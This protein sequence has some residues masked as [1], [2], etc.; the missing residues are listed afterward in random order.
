MNNFGIWNLKNWNLQKFGIWILCIGIFASSCNEKVSNK[1]IFRYNQVD[2]VESMDPAF[3]KNKNV[4]WHT[5]QLYNRLIE[6]GNDKIAMPSLAKRWTI[7]PDRKTYTFILRDDVYFHDNE[8]FPNSKGRKLIAQDV[9]FSFARIIDKKTASPGSWIFN[10]KVDTLKPFIALNDTTFQLSLLRPFN[11]MMGILSM[12]YCNI[13]PHEA[14]EKWGAD[15]RSHPCGT[16]AFMM[17]QWD[18]GSCITFIKNEHYWEKDSN[19]K[20]LPY[21]DGIKTTCVDSRATEFLLFMQNKLDF[22]NEIDASFKD[23]VITK[24]GELKKEYADK[25]VFQKQPQLVLEYLGFLVDESKHKNS[26]VLNRKIRQAINYGIDKQ[27]LLTYFRNSIG[28]RANAGVLPIGVLGYDSTIVKG[29]NYNPVLA[30]KLIDE[31]KKEIGK[32]ETIILLTPDNYADR[33]NFI[34]S[35]LNDIGLDIK[36]EIMQASLLREQMSKSQAQFFRAS[37]IADYPDAESFMAMFYSK[38]IAPP[39]YT[40]FNNAQFDK[41]YEQ[42]LEV[43]DVNQ[44]TGLYQQMDKIILEESPVIPVFYDQS[45]HFLQKKIKGFEAN[46]LNLIS[47]KKVDW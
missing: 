26:F 37:W 1:K 45:M 29:Y 34:A 33:C 32:T 10:D 41:L 20:Q 3:A 11:P 42:A 39:N 19:N 27:K 8:I 14:V 6:Y 5:N 24:Q 16:G 18:E 36:V 7:S 9:A 31:V 25:I 35:Q 12:Q 28:T 15:F 2:G 17:E 22:M 38:N 46:E 47:L 30:K 23:E 44:K 21:I 40:R 13:V 43:N 4:M